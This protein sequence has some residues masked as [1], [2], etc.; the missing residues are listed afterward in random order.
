MLYEVIT[1]GLRRIVPRPRADRRGGAVAPGGGDG[2][3]VEGE[4]LSGETVVARE[5][6]GQTH[7]FGRGVVARA[8]RRRLIGPGGA[9]I[10]QTEVLG[11][12]R[13]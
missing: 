6:R 2:R 7:G 10:Q 9:E 1:E 5:A 8:E 11:G 13:S 4:E 12:K 3:G